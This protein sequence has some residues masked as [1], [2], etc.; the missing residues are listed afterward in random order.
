LL[1]ERRYVASRGD[2]GYVA[3]IFEED[4]L[5]CDA[6][7]RHGVQAT[8]ADW[9]D[10]NVDW[11]TF[12]A[13]VFRTTWDYFD[14]FGEFQRWLDR[15]ESEVALINPAPLVRWNWDKHYLL[16]LQDAGVAIVD[17]V[18]F[19]RGDQVDLPAELETRGW[20]D[21]VL[22]PAVSGA[23][24]H[25]YRIRSGEAAAHQARLDTLLASEAMMLQPFVDSVLTDGE[26]T[27]VVIDG[28]VTHAVRKRAKPGDFRVQ[29]DFGGTVHS[30]V[31]TDDEV[32][33]AQTAFE[34][35]PTAP[36]YGR[37]D[38]VR[39]AD[40]QLRA[41][42]LELIE[43]ELWFRFHHPAADAFAEALVRRL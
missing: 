7:S 27:A 41:M 31:L 11:S 19:E 23:A 35:C 8:R 13:A 25:T 43:P 18:F 32:R 9:A 12:D 15:V 24:R 34:A 1:T 37:L 16:Q 4:R 2:G 10:P 28:Q 33:F 22:K 26:L 30:H 17:T 38:M 29:D 36:A 39:D 14:R 6:L 3:N 21:A 42:E 40:G 20:S 5:V